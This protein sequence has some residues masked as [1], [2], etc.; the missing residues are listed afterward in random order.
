MGYAHLQRQ[1]KVV[2][3]RLG[4]EVL[5]YD[6]TEDSA[7]SFNNPTDSYSASGTKVRCV[8]TYPNRNTEVNTVAGD[9]NRDNPIF[10]FPKGNAPDDEA[11]IEYPEDA[12]EVGNASSTTMYEM[13]APTEYDSHTEMFGRLVVNQ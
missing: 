13:Q 4:R 12:E 9:R 2:L 8:R 7:D 1:I 11:R 10:L 6:R 5:I 3:H